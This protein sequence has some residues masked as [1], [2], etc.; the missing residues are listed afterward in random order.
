M[1]LAVFAILGGV[2]FYVVQA[3]KEFRVR[4]GAATLVTADSSTVVRVASSDFYVDATGALRM[5]TPT[6][7]PTSARRRALQEDAVVD[8]EVAPTDDA[9]IIKSTPQ[10]YTV[11][12]LAADAPDAVFNALVSV[13]TTNSFGATLTF[14]VVG[15]S[16]DG[17]DVH[18]FTSSSAASIITLDSDGGVNCND[19]ST[20]L[21]DIWSGPASA[22]NG[23]RRTALTLTTPVISGVTAIAVSTTSGTT[24]NA[25]YAK[26][27]S[28]TVVSV[29][30]TNTSNYVSRSLVYSTTTGIFTG[31]I[32]ANLCPATVTTFKLATPTCFT[33]AFPQYTAST[34][35]AVAAPLTGALVTLSAAKG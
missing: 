32:T 5:R 33:Q 34:L 25:G 35:A 21:L 20:A 1:S 31:S 4:A 23:S 18:L 14:G 11:P 26:A 24:S 27:S 13:T 9:I 30:G 15:W 28:C 10:L 16:R 19:C 8:A 29:C 6:S 22:S 2:V 12:A 17:G 3:T 7:T